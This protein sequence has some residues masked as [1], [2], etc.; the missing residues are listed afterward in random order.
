MPRIP[1]TLVQR[2]AVPALF[3]IEGSVEHLHPIGSSAQSD[4]PLPPADRVPLKALDNVAPCQ[5]V[6][7]SPSCTWRIGPAVVTFPN[8]ELELSPVDTRRRALKF[9][10][11][12]SCIKF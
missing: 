11:A 6:N 12:C 1:G 10:A 5:N 7:R 3:R 8:V 2:L 4:H 9:Y